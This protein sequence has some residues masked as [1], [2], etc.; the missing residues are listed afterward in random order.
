MLWEPLSRSIP[1]ALSHA[2]PLQDA[3]DYLLQSAA[4]GPWES[5]VLSAA[6]QA[7]VVQ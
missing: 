4:C 7:C 1:D 3:R 2:L 5:R 6:V